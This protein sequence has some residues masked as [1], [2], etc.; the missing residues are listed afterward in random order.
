MAKES[1]TNKQTSEL[2]TEIARSREYVARD[3]RGVRYEMDVGRKIRRSFRRKP[4]VWVGAAVAVGTLLVLLPM[5][6][7][8]I[9]IEGPDVAR[10][11]KGK[12]K[13]KLLETGFLVGA[14]RLAFT[15]AKPAISR[16]VA[17][18]IS[19]YGAK[20]HSAARW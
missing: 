17:Q 20:R 14:L 1:R 19:G 6:K 2:K 4:A 16:F 3:L 7:R 12:R 10:S 9:Y 8:K 5:R 13:S 15:M 18:K 11:L